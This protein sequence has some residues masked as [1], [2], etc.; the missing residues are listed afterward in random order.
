MRVIDYTQWTV[1]FTTYNT[2]PSMRTGLK[3]EEEEEVVEEE[4]EEVERWLTLEAA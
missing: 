3:E 1:F 2:S 4:E